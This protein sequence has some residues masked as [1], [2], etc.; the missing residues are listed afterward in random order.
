MSVAYCALCGWRAPW[1]HPTLRAC[2]LCEVRAAMPRP[3]APGWSGPDAVGSLDLRMTRAELLGVL[4]S[5]L[6]K[7]F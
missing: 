4:A 3:L 2:G 5:R 7:S 1:L 6:P